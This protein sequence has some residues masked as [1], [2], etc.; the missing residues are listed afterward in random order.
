GKVVNDGSGGQTRALT[1]ALLRAGAEFDVPP[2]LVDRPEL[3]LTVLGAI[4]GAPRV[5]QLL[6]ARV[7]ETETPSGSPPLEEPVARCGRI[8]TGAATTTAY[9][10]P[11]LLST[12][13]TSSRTCGSRW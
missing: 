2:V 1:D 4:P 12:S 13:G 5:A 6:K 10:A 9:A 8:A 11:S 3:G 7:R